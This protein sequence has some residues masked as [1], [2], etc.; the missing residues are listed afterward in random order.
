MQKVFLM[1]LAL[2]TPA[3]PGLAQNQHRIGGHIEVGIVDARRQIVIIFKHQRRAGMG[4]QMGA[5]RIM[6][7]HRP[8]RREI[9]RQNGE[10]PFGEHG[11]VERFHHIVA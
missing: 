2:L 7:N 10:A 4:Q 3:V 5:G 1:T 9:A 8:L 11:L 6:L